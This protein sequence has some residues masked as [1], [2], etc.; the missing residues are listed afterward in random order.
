MN[1]TS[2]KNKIQLLGH[3]KSLEG[4]RGLAWSL[5]FIG[6]AELIPSLDVASVAM[7]LFF[8]LS[9]FLITQLIIGEYHTT[10]TVTLRQFFRRRAFRLL[11]ALVVFLGIWF[12]VVVLFRGSLWLTT[13]PGVPLGPGQYL[14]YHVALEGVGYALVYFTN[15]AIIL[16]LFTGYVPIGHLWSLSVEEQFYIIWTPLLVVLL[17]FGKKAIFFVMSLFC[18]AS[19]VETAVFLSNK[20][21]SNRI[22]MGTDTRAGSLFLGAIIGSLWAYKNLNFKN[23]F[24][25]KAI[26]LFSIASL[27]LVSFFFAQSFTIYQ[28]IAWPLA[29]I[30]SG[31]L[32]LDLV[33]RKDS[34]LAKYMSNPILTYLGR[35][36][37]ALYLWHYVWLTWF[38]HLGS[39]S[40]IGALF[41]S[42]VSA[43]ISWRIVEQPMQRIRKNKDLLKESQK[44]VS[45]NRSN[46]TVG[47]ID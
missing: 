32:I 20:V 12:L 22:Y 44:I 14:G 39:W 41:M 15:W 3:Q 10:G 18:I 5:V 30:A 16:H 21:W 19:V 17:P 43:E 9:G 6:H 8:T 23:R 35:R 26:P 47:I 31:L 24:F 38:R 29:S 37:Y 42:I 40:V 1:Q 4:L 11:P 33:K 25:L 2:S 27:L 13:V 46:Q 34:L 28:Q 45:Q 36:S 7:F